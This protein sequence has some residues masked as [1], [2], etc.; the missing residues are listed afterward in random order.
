MWKLYSRVCLSC[1]MGNAVSSVFG[2]WPKVWISQ[3]LLYQFSPL[4]FW[5]VF[6]HVCELYVFFYVIT[7][8]SL[9][10]WT[11][12]A[13]GLGGVVPFIHY[14]FIYDDFKKFLKSMVFKFT[15]HPTMWLISHS[16]CRVDKI[17]TI[18]Q[19][20]VLKCL[21]NFISW[22]PSTSMHMI[23]ASQSSVKQPGRGYRISFIYKLLFSHNHIK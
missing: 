18:K 22:N 1:I 17:K 3:P 9:N 21:Y 15:D 11:A 14:V 6:V 13:T 20:S 16:A 4:L 2:A 19:T 5:S 7:R 10:S 23:T 8:L 12:G